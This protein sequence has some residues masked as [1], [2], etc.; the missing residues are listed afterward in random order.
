MN[1]PH[2]RLLLNTLANMGGQLLGPILSLALVPLYLAFLGLEPYGLI[3]FFS[4]L[5]MLLGVFSQG[6]TH[7][8]QREFARRDAE[9]AA[10]PTM[11]RLAH[12]FEL[13]Y[14]GIGIASAAG[15]ALCAG[16]L[17]RNW[18]RVEAID[19][20]TVEIAIMLLAA[21]IGLAF[22]QGVYQSVFVGT[23]RQ[24]AL[25]AIMVGMALLGATLTVT[26]VVFTRS[27]VALY[28]GEALNAGLL[29]A[30]LRLR[31]FRILP[32]AGATETSR[33]SRADVAA[34]ARPSA[35][36]LWTS[37]IGII[38][39][40]FD[41]IL[42]SKLET[43]AQLA[44]YNA[45]IAGG[46]LLNMA[47]MPFLMAAY[48]ETCQIAAV[49]DR[50]KMVRHIVRNAT[51]VSA[52]AAASAAPVAFF[53]A[54]ILLAWTHEPVISAGGWRIMAIYIT[55]SYTLANASVFYMLQM[56]MGSVRQAAIYNTTAL[57]WYPAIMQVLIKARGT[58]GA[59]WAWLV[60]GVISWA[61]MAS[62]SFVRHLQPGCLGVYAR[63]TLV[64][65]ALAVAGG[66]LA[67]LATDAIAITHPLART[68]IAGATGALLLPAGL[69]LCLGRTEASDLIRKL[70][71]R[72]ASIPA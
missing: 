52:L 11:R 45:G 59:A 9:E 24:V 35:S 61:F 10:R 50:A 37:G 27:L 48:P 12:T 62:V 31:A 64:P 29:V 4:A 39:T 28:A 69:A 8:L 70:F 21:R 22:P 57:V 2:R 20:R 46:R 3:G 49:G 47:Y 33:F 6:I 40:Q 26:L 58:E 44:V 55:G 17:S 38:I 54:D 36:I 65:L 42:L 51:V 66:G 63:R 34:I 25:N 30:V 71:R 43:L 67:R 56:A 72:R 1:A 5:I 41:R 14:L 7:A 53:A 32:P 16:Y 18:I 23:Q 13:V 19:P 15:L 60:Y 68:A